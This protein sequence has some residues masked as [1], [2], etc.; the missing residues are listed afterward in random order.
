MTVIA[1]EDINSEFVME[2]RKLG[3]EVISVRES[4]RGISDQEVIGVA[5]QINEFLLTED[6]DFGN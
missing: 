3:F 4:R 6:K 2:L 5:K 1:D